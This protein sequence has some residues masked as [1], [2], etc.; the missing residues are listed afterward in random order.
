M[1]GSVA[2]TYFLM[3]CA[4]SAARAMAGGT[5]GPRD[6]PPFYALS[7]EEQFAVGL[8]H[9]VIIERE[10]IEVIFLDEVVVND[11]FYDAGPAEA[12]AGVEALDLRR[13]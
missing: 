1:G 12:D 9:D 13:L 5:E 3:P 7:P 4:V 2:A 10:D 8:I 11:L 6:Y